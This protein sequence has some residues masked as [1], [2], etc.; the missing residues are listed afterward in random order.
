V[1]L[2]HQRGALGIRTMLLRKLA[3]EHYDAVDVRKQ[4]IGQLLRHER[5]QRVTIN[6]G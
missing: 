1:R 6:Y 2:S 3:R 4:P 5:T